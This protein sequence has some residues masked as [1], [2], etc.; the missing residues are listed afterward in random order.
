MGMLP[1]RCAGIQV[2]PGEGQA[3]VY[4]GDALDTEARDLAESAQA[5]DT[6]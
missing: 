4:L 5:V 2:E 3:G 6:D 1:C